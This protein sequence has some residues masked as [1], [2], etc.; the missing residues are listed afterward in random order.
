MMR[1]DFM[2]LFRR[3]THNRDSDDKRC[4][5]QT[6]CGLSMSHKSLPHSSASLCQQIPHVKWILPSGCSKKR[7]KKNNTLM[8]FSSCFCFLFPYRLTLQLS[9][10]VTPSP[11]ALH[12]KNA[13]AVYFMQRQNNPSCGCQHFQLMLRIR[14]YDRSADADA[15]GAA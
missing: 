12:I 14:M 6:H 1:A 9:A 4:K 5:N 13:C 10:N 3:M 7:R 15:D 11:E 2:K 8:L